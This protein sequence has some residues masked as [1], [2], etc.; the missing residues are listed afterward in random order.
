MS[1]LAVVMP[2]EIK[3]AIT[4][5]VPL[6]TGAEFLESLNDGRAIFVNGERVKNVATHPAFAEGARSAAKLFDIAADPAHRERM[7]YT[8]P[9]TGGPVYRAFQIPRSHADLRAKRLAS[10]MWSE[11]SFGLMGRTPDHVSN[12][13]AGY[14]AAPEV[15]AAGGQHFADNVVNFYEHLRDNH[16]WATYAIVPPQIDRS[17]QA[18]QQSDASLFAG[19]VK[20]TD[21]GIYISGSQQLATGGVYSDWLQISCIQP[22][23]PGDENYAISVAVP[24]NA[25]GLRLY[26]RRPYA[27]G[28]TNKF[29][30]PLTSR[31]DETDCFVV[32]ENVF[33]PWEHVFI[34]RNIDICRDQW[35]KTPSHLYGNHQAQTRYATKLRFMMGLAKRINEMT[36]NDA[37]PAVQVQMG[38]LAA[39]VTTVEAMLEAQE[40]RAKIDDKGVLWPDRAT[41]YAVMALQSENNPR[42]INIVR[43]LA[44]ASMI[45]MPS[46]IEDLES[47]VTSAD[48]EKYMISGYA[49]AGARERMALM[50]MA[51][52]FVGTEFANRHQQY[53]KFYGGA[54]YIVKTNM[55]RNY[56]FKR[57]GDLVDRALALSE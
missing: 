24:I 25:E 34:Y 22:L 45:T 9:K 57:S 47:P 13:F 26:P 37:N 36:G 15:F 12:F 38:E 28:A 39:L 16:L 35:W 14:A 33:V 41:L 18:S 11:L 7:T 49:G 52:D 48:I 8:S 40:V 19:V 1:N 43:E 30:Y 3:P 29:D 27:L 46:S 50:R 31:F 44:G 20:E 54:S 23:R 6:R 55:F 5:P 17:K 42:M 2:A 4:K 21:A 10:E 32:C 51:W 56:D 53:E